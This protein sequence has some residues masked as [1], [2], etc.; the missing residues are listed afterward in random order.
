MPREPLRS[1]LDV[2]VA[3]VGGGYTGLWTARELLRRDPSLRVVVLE[4]AVCGF[5]ASGRNGGW[6]SAIYPVDDDVLINRYGFD[7]YVH[8]RTT[9]RAAVGELGAYASADGVD[10]SSIKGVHL[11]LPAVNFN[12]SASKVKPNRRVSGAT[13]PAM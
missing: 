3:I 12:C 11:L 2:D 1:H 13:K 4:Q 7:E 8:L 6:A 9:L 10:A 5:G